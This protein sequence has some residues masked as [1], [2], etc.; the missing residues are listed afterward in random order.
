MKKI[1]KEEFDRLTNV[2][3]VSMYDKDSCEKLIRQYVSKD[4]K[5]CKTCD[6]SVRQAFTL[7]GNWWD[8]NHKNWRKLKSIDERE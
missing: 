6:P 4:Y 3:R 5:F 8:T 2:K 7:L 1:E